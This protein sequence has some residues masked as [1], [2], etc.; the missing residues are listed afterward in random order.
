[1]ANAGAIPIL[2]IQHKSSQFLD[3]PLPTSAPLR[4]A[5][6]ILG[7]TGF[8]IFDWTQNYTPADVGMSF[9]A[10]QAI[11]DGT[12]TVLAARQNGFY[13]IDNWPGETATVTLGN[14]APPYPN[15]PCPT[16]DSAFTCKMY[17]VDDVRDYRA[18]AL[19]RIVKNLELIEVEAGEHWTIHAH[20]FIRYWGELVPEPSAITL[21]ALG[22]IALWVR[23]VRL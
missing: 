17:L 13:F 22:H 3:G 21:F 10:D 12:N 6:E 7:G 4:F 18:T 8:P 16:G 5:G 23:R 20:Q 1:L 2:E 11:V 15:D 19:E 14:L 9:F